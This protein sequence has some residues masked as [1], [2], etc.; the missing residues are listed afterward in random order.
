[1][2]D[3]LPP[4]TEIK[5]TSAAHIAKIN[6]FLGAMDVLQELEE[7]KKEH[8]RLPGMTLAVAHA[9][10]EV[11]IK[12]AAMTAHNI[13]LAGKHGWDSDTQTLGLE[14]KGSDLYLV[15]SPIEEAQPDAADSDANK[16]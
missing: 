10:V 14:S 13:I 7:L 6:R 12:Q 11:S 9:K 1:M 16:T 2:D 4:M 15:A 5:I 3:L 8:G